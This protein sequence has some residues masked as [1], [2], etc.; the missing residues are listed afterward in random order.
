MKVV[1]FQQVCCERGLFWMGT[2]VATPLVEVFDSK[3]DTNN[4]V[5]QKRCHQ[6]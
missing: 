2:E 6:F 3:D 1:C 4:E 5:I